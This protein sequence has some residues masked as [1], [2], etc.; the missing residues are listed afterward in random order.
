[1]GKLT[2]II[3]MAFCFQVFSVEKALGQDFILLELLIS[4]HKT[5]SDNLKQRGI[6]DGI[7]YG[8]STTEKNNTEEYMDVARKVSERMGSLYSY[9]TFAAEMTRITAL[10]KEVGEMEGTAISLAIEGGA[11]DP[12]LTTRIVDLQMDFGRMTKKI[13]DLTVFVVS[14]GLGVTMATQEQ[15]KEFTRILSRELY[16]MRAKLY[17][18]IS[19][20]RWVTLV[21]APGAPGWEEQ[22]KSL[23]DVARQ[24][25]ILDGIKKEIELIG[26]KDTR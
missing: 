8:V 10:A 22:A 15:R 25:G 26:N 13:V 12:R 9:L 16:A 4:Y 24:N 1:M 20:A 6:N 18:F 23:Y 2:Y 21:G 14:S 17:G 11:F 7:K 19:Y 5:H 3:V